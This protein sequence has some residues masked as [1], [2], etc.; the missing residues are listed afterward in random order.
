VREM[1]ILAIQAYQTGMLLIIIASIIVEFLFITNTLSM[2]IKDR[3][4]EFGTL[5]AIGSSN[6][7]IIIFLSL[8]FIIYA[9]IASFLGIVLGLVFSGV[10]VFILNFSFSRLRINALTIKFTTLLA[11][12]LTG[13]IITLMAGLYPII[14]ALTL[15]VI[16]TM[17]WAVS[18]KKGKIPFWPIS[19]VIGI[20]MILLGMITRDSVGSGG[21]LE[22][23]LLS[24]NFFVVG[25]IFLG[26]LFLE[27]GFLHFLPHIGGL[28]IWYRSMPR[29]IATRNIRR[30]SQ[31]STIT[32]M[33]TGL[34]LSFILIMGITAT[35]LIEYVPDYYNDKFGR[36]GI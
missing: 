33:V 3:S 28:M 21:F 20:V 31:K 35:A 25:T 19:M 27:I 22:F 24:W 6:L 17:H 15:P 26:L 7:Q 10:S 12:Y 8:E 16:Q 32:V 1:D 9:G 13:I 30:E 11:S 18:R 2:N 14:K 23:Q 29:T 4:K 5:K 34:A 36:I